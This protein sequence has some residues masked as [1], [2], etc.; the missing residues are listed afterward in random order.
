MVSLKTRC[1]G[2]EFENPF[3]LA[4]APPTASVDSIDKAFK[5]GWGGAVLKTI[6]PD[7]LIMYDLS[8]RYAS[9][10]SQKQVI[11]FENIELLSHESLKY[12]C[13]GIKQLKQ[14]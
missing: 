11:G 10:R 14:K 5:M 3:L 8:P 7:S 9:V 1:L 12:W 2:L 6:T 13:D 4:S